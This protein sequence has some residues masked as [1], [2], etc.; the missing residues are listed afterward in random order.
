MTM[1][2]ELK[3]SITETIKQNGNNEITGNILQ[4]VLLTMVSALGENAQMAGE[5]TPTTNPGTPDNKVFYVAQQP[6]VY[7]NFGG[8]TLQSGTIAFLF[9]DSEQ[10]LAT[11]VTIGELNAIAVIKDWNGNTLAITSK[12]VQLPNPLFSDVLSAAQGGETLVQALAKKANLASPALTGSPTAPTPAQNAA[13][14]RIAT[15]GFVRDYIA[16]GGGSS[17]ETNVIEIIYG[18]NNQPLPVINKAV[19][20]PS[21]SGANVDIGG[22]DLNTVLQT[23]E[24]TLSQKANAADVY[25][26]TQSDALFFTQEDATYWLNLKADLYS[27]AFRGIP[28]APTAANDSVPTQIATLQY[29]INKIAEAGSGG[30]VNKIEKIYAYGP[31]ATEVEVT[32]RE[33]WLPNVPSTAV[34]VEGVG[35]D[36]DAVL[37]SMLQSISNRAM[38]NN[39]SLTGTP[40]APTPTAS[41]PDNQ[42]ATKKYVLDNA[43]SGGNVRSNWQQNNPAA[44]SYV[45]NRTHYLQGSQ[46]VFS[47]APVDITPQAGFG[48]GTARGSMTLTQG[49]FYSVTISDGVT[50]YVNAES[51]KPKQDSNGN[52]Y[53]SRGWEVT[54]APGA[55][56]GTDAFL[57][58][59]NGSGSVMIALTA[60]QSGQMEVSVSELAYVK[61]PLGYIPD[62]VANVDLTGY[63]TETWVGSNYVAKETG[64]GLSTNDFTLAEKTKLA[65]IEAGAEKN[66]QGDWAQNDTTADDHI[67]NRTHYVEFVST[68]VVWE[69]S[70]CSVGS[71]TTSPGGYPATF[72]ITTGDKYN[73]TISQGSTSKTYEGLTAEYDIVFNGLALRKNWS[74]SMG[75][76]D[77]S[78]DA[79]LLV[80]QLS[81]VVLR[82]ADIYG[83]NCTVQVSEVTETIHKLDPKYL[84][85]NVNQLESVTTQESSVSGG[86]NVVTFTQTNGTQTSFNVKNGEKGD[87]GATGA[88]GPQGPQGATGPQGPKG[89]DGVSLGEIALTQEVTTA[90]DSV[91]ANKAVYDKVQR[92]TNEDIE[93]LLN[94][95][96][97]ILPNDYTEVEYVGNENGQSGIDTGFVPS[98]RGLRLVGK[99][100]RMTGTSGYVFS[101][102][103]TGYVM[104]QLNGSN[105]VNVKFMHAQQDGSQIT[106]SDSTAG[107]W[108]TFELKL[109]R[110]TIDGVT[111][112][113]SNSWWLYPTDTLKLFS[114]NNNTI[115]FGR[116]F[117]LDAEEM[118]HAYIPCRNSSNVYGMYDLIDGTF[119][120]SM[121][122]TGVTGGNDVIG[123]QNKLVNGESINSVISKLN[124]VCNA[125]DDRMKD[126]DV[127]VIMS[128]PST[129]TEA[130]Q[131]MNFM[132]GYQLNYNTSNLNISYEV[133][134]ARCITPYIPVVAGQNIKLGDTGSGG[135]GRTVFVNENKIFVSGWSGY[136]N[137]G[138][139]PS[140]AVYIR[141]TFS[142]ADLDKSYIIDI[143]TNEII[144]DGSTV[145]DNRGK[146]V[147]DVALKGA[148]DRTRTAPIR[149]IEKSGTRYGVLDAKQVELLNSND[150]AT[151]IITWYREGNSYYRRYNTW[152]YSV[153]ANGVRISGDVTNGFTVNGVA[154]SGDSFCST[155]IIEIN[156]VE[157]WVK[158]WEEG[159]LRKTTTNSAFIRDKFIGEDG[160]FAFMSADGVSGNLLNLTILTGAIC[161]LYGTVSLFGVTQFLP[162]VWYQRGYNVGNFTE[163]YI[164]LRRTNADSVVWETGN[165]YSSNYCT[166]TRNIGSA[167]TGQISGAYTDAFSTYSRCR[168][169]P[170]DVLSG[171]FIAYPDKC[172][173]GYDGTTKIYFRNQDGTRGAEISDYNNIGVGEYL[174]YSYPRNV[175]VGSGGIWFDWGDTSTA[176]ASMKIYLSTVTTMG[177]VLNL[178]FDFLYGGRLYE[179][180]TDK[181]FKMYQNNN[182]TNESMP[183]GVLV[184]PEKIGCYNSNYPATTGNW[185][186]MFEGKI[187]VRNN[188]VYMAVWN[189]TGYT[190]K[191]INNS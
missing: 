189:G 70:G 86:T 4:N 61:L 183:V 137:S 49:K 141:T 84:P 24:N 111:T 124:N 72:N 174:N 188:N 54:T 6:G 184:N 73:V 32:E 52:W 45:E 131:A 56:Q 125:V 150:A 31:N 170:F 138:S 43:A 101:A 103:T 159:T 50:T 14:T 77:T 12:S 85:D 37:Q 30:D 9:W 78:T 122:A 44:D 128:D 75:M 156:R 81:N 13:G 191:Q 168:I 127:D 173:E 169:T 166:L 160:V 185:L 60:A 91:P 142:L 133:N 62:E 93:A 35:A 26:R 155:T 146:L 112:T 132:P 106:L 34:I 18:Y 109:S 76:S 53:L 175:G 19:H 79:L 23:I 179:M 25:T 177:C 8:Y 119:L 83:E 123:V 116:F 190:W 114:S 167:K 143:D 58:W 65:D 64:K 48:G 15:V 7:S 120:T 118:I 148:I 88:T 158:F 68:S 139:V 161:S 29:V 98:S 51:L 163:T 140:N 80:V 165:Q 99:W 136:P 134:A 10:W 74:D 180:I 69:Q 41:S 40:T 38:K 16:G 157:G 176:E 21:V 115:R 27:P 92:L 22:V 71:G 95:Y 90:T 20:L 113:M 171:Y 59:D 145:F 11:T 104:I 178:R 94:E 100:A 87:T 181:P 89:D 135:G 66:V 47:A 130:L 107:S 186:N 154:V 164:S 149:G 28:T 57:V 55:P 144:F 63:A 5:A 129:D 126:W 117:V 39:A 46:L 110:A 67:K 3:A 97:V 108:H 182:G 151:F 105:K 172:A 187:D 36:L 1:W 162:S 121:T 152:F 102:V 147:G 96:P 2:D 17:G 82:S 153:D 33:A 42:I